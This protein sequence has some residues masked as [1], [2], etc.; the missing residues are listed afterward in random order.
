MTALLFP[1]IVVIIHESQALP[2]VVIDYH[3]SPIRC[4]RIAVT[5][6]QLPLGVN[7]SV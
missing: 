1:I 3:V 5:R 4:L 7:R 6:C 2:V